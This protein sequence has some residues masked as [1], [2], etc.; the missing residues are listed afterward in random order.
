MVFRREGTYALVA[1]LVTLVVAATLFVY[2]A[3]SQD[4]ERQTEK[5]VKKKT[6]KRNE[7]NTGTGRNS[8]R[9]AESSGARL[10]EQ[11]PFAVEALQ[12]TLQAQATQDLDGEAVDESGNPINLLEIEIDEDDCNIDPG[13]SITFQVNDVG[14]VSATVI[15]GTNADISFEGGT[16]TV[17]DVDDPD[18]P[19]DFFVEL[20][21]GDLDVRRLDANDVELTI[22][23]STIDCGNDDNNDNND[24]DNDNNNRR[25]RQERRDRFR[26][27][28]NDVL[29]EQ[30]LIDAE[31]DLLNDEASTLESE[32]D[33]LNDEASTLE[34]S[35]SEDEDNLKDEGNGVS[36]TAD[37]NGAEAST[38]GAVAR[39]GGDPDE[40]APLRSPPDDVVDEIPT[41][42]PLP[43]TGGMSPVYW[44]L[45]LGGLVI[46]AGLP[47]YRWIKSRG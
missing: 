47:V 26:D 37:E 27:R 25:D 6:E 35:T 10:V 17:E 40:Q 12:A 16:I 30:D 3:W 19:I 14:V 24:D 32:D 15:D 2:P 21:N 38:P 46:L 1:I 42:G 20:D 33:L 9:T 44:L 8:T 36:A 23:T 41:S 43:N 31:D 34:V 28:V 11:N 45:P 13:D 22:D 18:A 7:N 29:R 5:K 4:G 39:S